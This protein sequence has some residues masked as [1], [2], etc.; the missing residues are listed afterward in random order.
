MRLLWGGSAWWSVGVG[1][2][3]GCRWHRAVGW[4]GGLVNCLRLLYLL[5]LHVL[6]WWLRAGSCWNTQR[7]SLLSCS[8]RLPICRLLRIKFVLFGHHLRHDCPC[9]RNGCLPHRVFVPTLV[10]VCGFAVWRKRLRDCGRR[11]FSWWWRRFHAL[12]H[13]GSH[14]KAKCTFALQH[15]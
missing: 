13:L 8:G 11:G 12:E 14:T 2:D 7:K 4:R 5:M 1:C 9:R 3:S 15:G 6:H 10:I